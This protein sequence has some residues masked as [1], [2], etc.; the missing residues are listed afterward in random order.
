[1]KV[2][3][4]EVGMD[5]PTG[6]PDTQ[7]KVEDFGGNFAE[8]LVIQRQELAIPIDGVEIVELVEKDEYHFYVDY[9][10]HRMNGKR[11]RQHHMPLESKKLALWEKEILKG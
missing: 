8:Y 11:V 5:N 2:M 6:T 4:I 1:M 3:V 10:S 9:I 7:R